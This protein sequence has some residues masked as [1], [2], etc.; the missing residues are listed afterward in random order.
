MI[1]K[2]YYLQSNITIFLLI[3][4]VVRILK[5]DLVYIYYL[6]LLFLSSFIKEEYII[7]IKRTPRFARLLITFLILLLGLYCNNLW[8]SKDYHDI[9]YCTSFLVF[10][11]LV[12]LSNILMRGIEKRINCHYISLAKD[13][14]K[15]VNCLKIGITGSYGKTSMKDLLYQ[16]YSTK[17]VTLKTP[18]SYNT[19]LGIVK[20]INESL[21]FTTEI[22]LVE[23]GAFRRHEIEESCEVVLPNVGV[24][25]GVTYQHME[26]FKTMENLIDTKLELARFVPANSFVVMPGDQK[27]L[28]DRDQV[29]YSSRIYVGMTSS[30]SFQEKSIVYGNGF[31]EFDI[32]QKK[33]G[34]IVNVLHIKTKLLGS[35]QVRNV[36]MAYALNQNIPQKYQ[37][38]D[39]EFQKTVLNIENP[40][41][42][43]S[44]KKE[45]DWQIYDDSY[46]LN[47]EGFQRGCDYIEKL[48]GYKIIIT[49]GLVD[50]GKYSKKL[51]EALANRMLFFD[52]IYLIHHK[53]SVYLENYF[54]SNN[55]AY[56]SFESFAK[57]F[58]FLKTKH[59]KDSIILYL[60]N[61]L[62]DNYLRR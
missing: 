18:K 62:P 37:L 3:Y 43:F 32:L 50:G 2:R 17:Y 25:T 31:M 29:K 23:M 24:I 27:I 42:R 39:E 5:N 10:P 30:C 53:E 34:K 28:L 13:K 48:N 40:S 14:I 35:H 6:L 9:L 57:A 7:R 15:T 38:S 19:Q 11:W 4:P 52:E 36:V 58:E 33:D 16:I 26:T 54:K 41:H 61:D 21:N 22:F 45:K 8:I 59:G 55:H 49:P 56:D 46:N 44:F 20:T 12:L 1:L 47:L 60:A 51:N